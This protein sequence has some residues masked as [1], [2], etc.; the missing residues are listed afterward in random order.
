MLFA[1][2]VLTLRRATVLATTMEARGFGA[3]GRRTWARPSRLHPRDWLVMA[4]GVGLCLASTGAGLAAGT[5]HLLL[6]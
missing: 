6:S 2:L 4:G 1:L 5:W 3:T